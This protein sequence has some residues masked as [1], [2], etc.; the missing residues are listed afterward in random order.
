M[1][2]FYFQQVET[3][4]GKHLLFGRFTQDSYGVQTLQVYFAIREAKRINARLYLSPPRKVINR[5]LFNLESPE[6]KIIPYSWFT[7]IKIRAWYWLHDI[8]P[9]MMAALRDIRNTILYWLGRFVGAARKEFLRY[10]R[11]IYRDRWMAAAWEPVNAEFKIFLRNIKTEERTRVRVSP[12]SPSL[13]EGTTR[14][15][16]SYFNRRD[17]EI[18]ISLRLNRGATETALRTARKLGLTP[19]KKI[20]TCHI[21]ESGSRNE[22]RLERSKFHHARSASVENYAGAFE[23]LK[24]S[25]F[26]IVRIGASTMSPLNYPGV[27]DLATH[28]LR[29]DFLEYWC[30]MQ[31]TFFLCCDSGPV[32]VALLTNTPCLLVNS[33]NPVT[34]YPIRKNSLYIIKHIKDRVTG[35]K[36][37]LNEMLSKEFI[38]DLDGDLRYL[39]TDNS[40]NE[41][42][43]AVE[44]MLDLLKNNTPETTLQK[45]YREKVVQG[46]AE[47][48]PFSK[49]IRKWGEDRGFIG[50]G[51]IAD[52]F[53][54]E[55]F[56][57]DLIGSGDALLRN[58]ARTLEALEVK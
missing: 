51:R 38:T 21:R 46:A 50:N 16:Y 40:E 57:G 54:K 56:A 4:K 52:F 28:P 10:A 14:Y 17:I 1:S 20:V 26:V 22:V 53:V 42:R 58:S 43:R 37:T 44:E 3:G 9:A 13:P 30:L 34:G 2:K 35:R 32:N 15:V 29:N 47:A 55:N 33:P 45:L 24:K 6:V 19:N 7:D 11:R 48:A 39:F 27:I 49:I 23:V 36:V 5:S 31:S 18:P 41:I 12:S 8:G 25:G